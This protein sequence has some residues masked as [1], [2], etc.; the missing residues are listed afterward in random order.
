MIRDAVPADAAACARIYAR[1]VTDTVISFEARPPTPSEVRCR[2]EQAHLWLIAEEDGEVCGYAHGSPHREREAYGWAADVS[3]Y[4]AAQHHRRGLGRRL[5]ARLFDGL[6]DR[7]ACTLCAGIALPNPASEALHRGM[8]FEEVGT[9]RRIGYKLGRWVDVRWYQ[10]DLRPN[11]EAPPGRASLLLRAELRNERLFADLENLLRYSGIR[12]VAAARAADAI[13]ARTG[14][15]WVGIYTRAK[16]QIANEAWSG[17]A[18]PIHPNFPDT[19]G[20]TAGAVQTRQ[21]VRCDQVANDPRY[22]T[23]R[24]STG[25]A[26]IVPIVL[27]GQVAGTLDI[28]GDSPFAFDENDQRLAEQLARRLLP[29]WSLPGGASQP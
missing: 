22:V 14:W 19:Q 18:P 25:A 11:P 13:R 7:G 8:G 24:D 26:I 4:L 12:V 23:N 5:Y 10:L 16:G 15:R 2:M 21:T 17:P 29:L 28:E 20:L 1:Y 27:D 6:R 9:Y 3:I